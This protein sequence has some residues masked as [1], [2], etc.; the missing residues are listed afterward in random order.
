MWTDDGIAHASL[1]VHVG[2][3]DLAEQ[4]DAVAA[5][6]GAV[7]DAGILQ[8]AL[9]EAD[10][11]EQTPLFALGGMILEVLAEVALVAS[12]GNGVAHGGQLDALQVAEFG[13]Q[14][15]VALL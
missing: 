4:S 5:Q 15:V 13:Y 14:L 12:L 9:T 10:L 3:L 11:T 2:H 8:H 7:D 1:I 6:H